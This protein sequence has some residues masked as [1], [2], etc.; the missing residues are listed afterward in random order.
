MNDTNPFPILGFL[1]HIRL[2]IGEDHHLLSA[3]IPVQRSL[4]SLGI[5]RATLPIA[6][7]LGD[8]AIDEFAHVSHDRLELRTRCPAP[9]PPAQVVAPT[10]P[11]QSG[12]DNGDARG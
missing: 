12:S 7:L 11:S 4:E 6:L 9:E 10:A 8:D 3:Q 5:P 2:A 1:V